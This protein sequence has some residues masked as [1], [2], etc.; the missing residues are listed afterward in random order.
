MD[1]LL[2]MEKGKYLRQVCQEVD[3]ILS[4]V[5][6]AVN[7]APDG[8]VLNRSEMQVWDVLGELRKAVFEKAVLAKC[9][10]YRN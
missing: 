6:D 2:R 5:A 4:Q 3:R 8:S 1:R 7:D 9:L 10:Y